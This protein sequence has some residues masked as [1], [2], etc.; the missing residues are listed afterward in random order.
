[1]EEV[2]EK[3]RFDRED[4]KKKFMEGLDAI[5]KR[6]KKVKT[7]LAIMSGKGGVG[8]STV[9]ALLAVHYGKNGYKTGIMDCDFWGSSIPLSLIHI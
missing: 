7:K 4:V 1:M 5:E 9:T 6:L 3:M 2:K 8:K